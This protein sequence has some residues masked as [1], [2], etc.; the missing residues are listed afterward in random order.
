M[1]FR[2]EI[3]YLMELVLGLERGNV[4]GKRGEHDCGVIK[5]MC[6]VPSSVGEQ[7]WHSTLKQ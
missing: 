3:V 6:E 7:E 2:I 5:W 1:G 4:G